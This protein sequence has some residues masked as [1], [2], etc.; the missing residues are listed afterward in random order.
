MVRAIWPSQ[1]G[2]AVWSKLL[3]SWDHSKHFFFFLPRSQLGIVAAVLLGPGGMPRVSPGRWV[4]W[5]R[6][7]V[8]I[9]RYRLCG[10][11][12]RALGYQLELLGRLCCMKRCAK[13]ASADWD[14]WQH[15]MM[16]GSLLMFALFMVSDLNRFPMRAVPG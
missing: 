2:L 14:V 9:Y 7:S 15:K 5:C 1:A 10:I 16:S 13:S 3:L 4:S 12:S 11:K 8:A 6:L